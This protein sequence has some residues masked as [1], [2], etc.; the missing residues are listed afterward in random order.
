MGGYIQPEEVW[1][2]TTCNACGDACPIELDPMSIIIDLR[3]EKVRLKR[4][5][6]FSFSVQID[7]KSCQKSGFC[8]DFAC[9]YLISYCCCDPFKCKSYSCQRA[10]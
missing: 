5:A 7:D 4:A 10:D 9:P 3:R 2:C 1:A 6:Q 8:A